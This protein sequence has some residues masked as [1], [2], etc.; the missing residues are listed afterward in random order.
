MGP[1]VSSASVLI[2]RKRQNKAHTEPI[3]STEAVSLNR[4]TRDRLHRIIS[5][6]S[7]RRSG[8]L[9]GASAEPSE[10]QAKPTSKSI[11]MEFRSLA[12]IR[13]EALTNTGAM[14]PWLQLLVDLEFNR[15]D[16]VVRLE[17]Q[18][19]AATFRSRQ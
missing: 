14:R 7:N 4:Y 16:T 12:G 19:H 18:D 9:N 17:L 13:L 15:R 1:C 10:Y 2:R 11:W 3:A 5:A 8:N 6:L